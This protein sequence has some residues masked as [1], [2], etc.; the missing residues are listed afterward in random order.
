M[1]RTGQRTGKDKKTNRDRRETLQAAGLTPPPE[2]VSGPLYDWRFY[3]A[4]AI[5][6][7]II[8]S[9]AYLLLYLAS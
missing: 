9:A 5:I 6:A 4:P 3:I 1:A 8:S 7:G 2:I